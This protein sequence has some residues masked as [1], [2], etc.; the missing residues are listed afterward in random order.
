MWLNLNHLI[1]RWFIWFLLKEFHVNQPSPHQNHMPYNCNA[2]FNFGVKKEESFLTKYLKFLACSTHPLILCAIRWCLGIMW[3]W[4][5]RSPS[6]RR[7]S[8]KFIWDVSSFCAKKWKSPF[9]VKFLNSLPSIPHISYFIVS[10]DGSLNYG[11][12]REGRVLLWEGVWMPNKLGHPFTY[13]LSL[14]KSP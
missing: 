7:N 12:R 14:W 9:H 4:K 11:H 13:V 1:V 8:T 6:L 5:R 10:W 2:P 3:A